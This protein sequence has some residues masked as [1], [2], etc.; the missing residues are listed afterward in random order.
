MNN[1]QFLE[2][3]SKLTTKGTQTSIED[4]RQL[5]PETPDNLEA[6][7]HLSIQEDNNSV[8]V[9]TRSGVLASNVINTLE[10]TPIPPE[11]ESRYPQINNNEWQS[12]L[13]FCT[14]VLCAIERNKES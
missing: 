10:E 7:K 1:K 13:R 8:G 5:I 6:L 2:S 11:I 4:L 3:I 14:L 9:G 12:L